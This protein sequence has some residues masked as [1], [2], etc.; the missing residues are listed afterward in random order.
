MRH[1]K[2]RMP[3]PQNIEVVDDDIAVILRR[4][5]GMEKIAMVASGWPLL[6]AMYLFQ[7]RTGHPGW[8]DSSL[9]AEVSRRMAHGST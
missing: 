4:K 3:N 1:M 5:T 6:R 8:N 9:Q 2:R 7:V